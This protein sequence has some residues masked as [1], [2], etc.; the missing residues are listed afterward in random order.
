MTNIDIGKWK[1]AQMA[2]A[3]KEK[4]TLQRGDM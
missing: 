2:Y 4:I 1:K 3:E